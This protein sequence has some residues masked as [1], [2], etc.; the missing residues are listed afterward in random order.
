[1][2]DHRLQHG[3]GLYPIVGAGLGHDRPQRQA[4]FVGG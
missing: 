3:L 1:L 2:Q 4:V